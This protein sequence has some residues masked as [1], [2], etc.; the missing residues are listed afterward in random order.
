M[1]H[2][3]CHDILSL[4]MSVSLLGSRFAVLLIVVILGSQSFADNF[5]DGPPATLDEPMFFSIYSILPLQKGNTNMQKIADANFTAA[6]P[7]YGSE[8]D[9]TVNPSAFYARV[10]EAAA[11]GLNY[12]AHIPMHP[13]VIND[14]DGFI[15]DNSMNAISEA[16]LRAHVRQVMDFTLNSPIANETVSTWFTAPEELRPWR[17]AEMNYLSI[18]ADEVKSYD[19]LGR[20]VA[21]YN[22]THRTS[23]QLETVVSQG[24]DWTMMGVYVTDVAFE[25][26]GARVADGVD[27]IVNAANSSISTPVAVFQLSEDFDTAEILGLRNALGGVS[28]AEAIK[29]VIRHDVYQGLLR[30]TQAMQIW[31]GCDCRTG[32]TTYTEQLDGYISVSENLNRNLGLSNVF[33]QGEHRTDFHATVLSGHETVTHESTTIDTVTLADIAYGDYRYLFLANSSN[34]HLA[35]SVDGL[36]RGIP[37]II[38]LFANAS[39]LV[40]LNSTGQMLLTM[41]P[42]EV[43]ALQIESVSNADAD[44]DG[45]VDGRDFLAWQ[46]SFGESGATTVAGGDFNYDGL[47]DSADLAVWK[48]QFNASAAAAFSAAV[49]EPSCSLMA[50]GLIWFF[51]TCRRVQV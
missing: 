37:Q 4:G 7:Y 42:L 33:L 20:A 28:Q 30:G 19:P 47:V 14:T 17:T 31:S 50:V 39:D 35:I 12:I 45:D 15:R 13:Y 21:M 24:L 40:V 2:P 34:S 18:V 43:I 23:S 9:P 46:G 29:Q 22:P 1:K 32:L 49:P 51:A 26:R 16:D 6:G 8:G 3:K 36:P 38:D 27:R 5:F 48:N 41:E 44:G 11:R 10:G 25:T